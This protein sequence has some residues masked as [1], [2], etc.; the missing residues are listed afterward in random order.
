MKRLKHIAVVCGVV[1][2]GCILLLSS[3]FN[4]ISTA[5]ADNAIF[6][7]FEDGTDGFTAPG[8]LS[9]NAGNPTQSAS[10]HTEGANSLALPVNFTGGS[11]DQAG[12]DK[13]FNNYNPVDLTVYSA[14]SYDVYAPVANISTDLVFNDP[15]LQPA[16]VKPLKVGW[17]TVTFDISPTSQDFPNAGSYFST[18]KEF[19]LRAIGQGATYNGPV[20]FDNVRFIP[21]THPVVSMLAPHADDTLSVPQ[22]QSYTIKAHVA[23]APGRQITGVQFSTP[24]QSGAMTYD[25]TNNIYTAPWDL[26]REGE[27][28]KT[29]TITAT[30][31]QG[32]TTTTQTSVLVQDS[33]LQVHITAP[34]FDQQLQDKVLV[35]AKIQADMRFQLQ[36]VMLQTGVENIPMQASDNAGTYS[37]WVNTHML[38]DGVHTFK[39]VAKDT[40]FKVSDQVD[41]QVDNHA[42]TMNIIHTNDTQFVDGHKA[43]S[44]VGWNEYDLFTRTDQTVAS[45]EQSSE[46]NI[47]LKGTTLTWQEQI[48]RQMLEAERNHLTVLRTW[49]FDNTP[50]DSSAFQTAPGQYNEATFQKLDYIVASAQHHHLRVILTMENYWNDY[51][52]IQQ[53]A[54]WLNLPNKLAFFTDANAQNYYKQYV[55]HLVN[56]VNTVSHVTYKDDPTVFAWELM[57]EP[58]MDCNDDPT[59][60]H[61]YCDPSGKTLQNWIRMMS[62]YV[63]SLD[64]QH[65]V[66]TGSEGHGFIPTGPNGQGI[67][68]AGTQEGNGNSP[69]MIQD[70]PTVDFVTFHPYPNASWANLNLQ[71][72][73]QLIQ[74]ITQAGLKLHKPVIMEEYGIDRSLPVFNEQGQTVQPTD[75]SYNTVRIQWYK[76]MMNTLYTSGGSGSNFWQMADWSDAHYNVN[77]Y[78]PQ[79]DAERDAPLM[80]VFSNKAL[81]L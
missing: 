67:Q 71:Q 2:S 5:H 64:P 27:G 60:N 51:G 30:D 43:F 35:S 55:A 25:S 23:P 34:Q 75:A 20:Y 29:L 78:L 38:P 58:R 61:Q 26:W 4:P 62:G 1:V 7:G 66:A 45:N 39:V 52:G 47:I 22:G 36:T 42:P 37:A 3:I 56:R 6:Y 59:P 33:Q 63:K 9:A 46:G 12:V 13:V 54:K 72:T 81:E 16:N 24:T 74:G 31:N 76:E 17:N 79:V 77:P 57:N 68:W 8:W 73:K 21:T 18:A 48:D 44:Y 80:K 65:M 70:V 69:A 15:W 28:L 10:Q 41:I 53:Y 40:Q 50:S 14:V 32:S 19:L 49:A 11:W